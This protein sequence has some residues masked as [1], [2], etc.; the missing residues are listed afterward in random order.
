[1][2]P[3]RAE[4]GKDVL[5]EQRTQVL[6][7]ALG[8]KQLRNGPGEQ[9]GA[10]LESVHGGQ[11]S[12][13]AGG[14]SLRAALIGL[15][16]ELEDQTDGILLSY[17][18]RLRDKVHGGHARRV[19]VLD[20]VVALAHV[21]MRVLLPQLGVLGIEAQLWEGEL[22][23]QRLHVWT[24]E[25]VRH[26]FV[27]A[28]L[29]KLHAQVDAARR[30]P[31]V[32]IDRRQRAR[33]AS[34]RRQHLHVCLEEARRPFGQKDFGEFLAVLGRNLGVAV[35][36]VQPAR[37]VQGPLLGLPPWPL[38]APLRIV[39]ARRA[40]GGHGL[41]DRDE[42][43]LQPHGRVS[44]SRVAQHWRKLEEGCAP[45]HLAHQFEHLGDGD[46]GAGLL[47]QRAEEAQQR[48]EGG[49]HHVAHGTLLVVT[50]PEFVLAR[51]DA[52]R[53]KCRARARPVARAEARL[54]GR[55]QLGE[56]LGKVGVHHRAEHLLQLRA[57]VRRQLHE[58]LEQRGAHR[59]LILLVQDGAPRLLGALA[60]PSGAAKIF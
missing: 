3:W 36:R 1:M 6:A 20:D 26:L 54:H 35:A 41:G 10:V 13:V 28:V 59:G 11:R 60:V 37:H 31:R 44:A 43:A 52:Q 9:H 56:A 7:V 21:L 16:Q 33:R 19:H 47:E 12:G 8:L 22:E 4:L 2:P 27:E 53:L 5:L 45:E 50:C 55:Q 49:G 38:R 48:G 29:E 42:E 23:Q 58:R 32:R 57:Q 15:R 14:D 25:L 39:R 17:A 40:L 51:D 30:Q 34:Q 24:H 46:V 18:A